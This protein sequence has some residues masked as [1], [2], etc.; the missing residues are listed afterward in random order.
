MNYVIELVQVDLG[1][2]ELCFAGLTFGSKESPRIFWILFPFRQKKVC[3]APDFLE[4]DRES[5]L[6]LHLFMAI[7]FHLWTVNAQRY[8]K[9][10]VTLELICFVLTM[11]SWKDQIIPFLNKALETRVCMGSL[12]SCAA[13]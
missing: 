12:D 5:Q 8:F 13:V 2:L 3:F 7:R 10:H 4:N 9:N 1:Y 6:S 11:K